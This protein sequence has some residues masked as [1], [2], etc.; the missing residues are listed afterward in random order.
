MGKLEA[1][2][3]QVRRFRQSILG[4]AVV[5]RFQNE[6]QFWEDDTA[7]NQLKILSRSSDRPNPSGN[8]LGNSSLQVQEKLPA[9][10]GQ[11]TKEFQDYLRQHNELIAM[12]ARRLQQAKQNT[13]DRLLL[14]P[15]QAEL[16]GR[17]SQRYVPL[18]S[19]FEPKSSPETPAT[20]GSKQ[21]ELEQS[22]LKFDL[23]VESST[24]RFGLTDGLS[25][26]DLQ[27]SATKQIVRQESLQDSDT[28]YRFL[29]AAGGSE[30][31]V[32][33]SGIAPQIRWTPVEP[34]ISI[35][36]PVTQFR[37]NPFDLDP[38]TLSVSAQAIE[39]V[40]LSLSMDGGEIPAGL[41]FGL[42]PKF[43]RKRPIT[44]EDGDMSLQVTKSFDVYLRNR[45]PNSLLGKPI[46]MKLTATA[47]DESLEPVEFH[48][49]VT[50]T[51]DPTVQMLARREIGIGEAPKTQASLIRWGGTL[52]D[53]WLPLTIN[54][55]AN[56][57][58]AFKFS[59]VNNSSRSKT[60]RAELYN[61]VDLPPDFGNSQIYADRPKS[62]QVQELASWLFKQ[63]DR[64][65][66]TS[67]Q[68]SNQDLLTLIAET[69]PIQV[70][71]GGAPVLANFSVPLV[72]EKQAP[73]E[74]SLLPQSVKQGMLIVFYEDQMN[75]PAWFQWLVY[76]PKG[77]SR[78]D[79]RKRWCMATTAGGYFGCFSGRT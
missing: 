61:L 36:S 5:E 8:I 13:N 1:K 60:L 14:T 50:L 68:Q 78:C 20:S 42:G 45:R 46:A 55:L 17:A 16:L 15:T 38:L 71:S 24:S 18:I 58:S 76:E 77:T 40:N 3:L 35:A 52:P 7:I 23:E 26:S 39:L 2:Q 32:S 48:F 4:M 12:V 44:F 53:N 31:T 54:S 51:K 67:L 63:Q 75:K 72:G 56:V 57:R 70:P 74:V 11:Y 66:A 9:A 59:L 27:E 65:G 21:D 34:N 37:V 25:I 64:P 33:R 49:T 10:V 41:E 22:T 28:G 29:L 79:G 30:S 6:L 19:A 43:E 47:A 62:D 73:T 69:Q